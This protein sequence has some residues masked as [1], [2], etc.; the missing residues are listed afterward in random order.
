[1]Q[2]V[3]YFL[4]STLLVAS[5][6]ANAEENNNESRKT[7]QSAQ[8]IADFTGKI[9]RDRVR[10]RLQP[11]LESPIVRELDRDD[12]VLVTG[13]VDDFYAVS[14]PKDLK[15]YVYK[16]FVIDN[17]VQGNRVN[18]RLNPTLEAPVIVQLNSGDKVVGDVSDE[19]SK[20]LEIKF[21]ES[22]R[23]YVSKDYIVEAGDANFITTVDNRKQEVN[24]L[25]SQSTQMAQTEIQKPF[26]EIHLE[27]I[28]AN[29]NRIINHYEDFPKQVHEAKEL[30][31]NLQ[32]TY[33]QKKVGYLESQKDN[34]SHDLE[35]KS[36]RLAEVHEQLNKINREN[37]ATDFYKNWLAKE[38]KGEIT[39]KMSVWIPAEISHYEQWA[40]ENDEG[41]IQ[42][43]YQQQSQQAV[44][45]RGILE[46]YNRPIRNKPG[47]FVLINSANNLP[48]AYLYSTQVNLDDKVGEEVTVQAVSR[49]NNHFAYPAFFVIRAD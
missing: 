25:L 16:S 40:R 49:P 8:D 11:T 30:Q 42:E 19:N 45:L 43:F 1:M 29:L 6:F 7:E 26:P 46:V 18:V 12:L 34:V 21:P 38:D 31:K 2:K 17:V 28:Y 10:L 9:T 23:F 33:L 41:S 32:D 5:T 39:N 47:D 44:A 36:S 14:P 48:I 13:V 4:L 27:G 15:A 24:H 3:K 20:W 22:L 35:E 37:G